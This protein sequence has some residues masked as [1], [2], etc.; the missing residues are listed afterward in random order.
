MTWGRG[1]FGKNKSEKELN[2]QYVME[3]QFNYG[4]RIDEGFEFASKG[5]E[6]EW[7]TP[8]TTAQVFC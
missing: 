5:K 1:T 8:S 7:S 3:A 2:M 6:K 4:S